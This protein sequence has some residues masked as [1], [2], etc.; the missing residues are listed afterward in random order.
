[1]LFFKQLGEKVKGRVREKVPNQ[2]DCWFLE[3]SS[4]R[5]LLKDLKMSGVG[6]PMAGL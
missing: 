1:M 6:E 4:V 2:A 5:Y 3:W